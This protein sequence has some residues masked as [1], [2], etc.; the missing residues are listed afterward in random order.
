MDPRRRK[1]H[2]DT[3]SMV[4]LL[5]ALALPGSVAAPTTLDEATM[6]SSAS[7]R[8]AVRF[9][10]GAPFPDIAL[11]RLEGGAPTSLAAFRGDKIIL[12]VFASW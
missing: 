8:A 3:V 2:A 6:R 5:A 11:P 4:A 7:Q 9:E 10:V 1:R 12:H